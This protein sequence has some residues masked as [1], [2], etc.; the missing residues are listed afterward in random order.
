M[1]TLMNPK[2]T[3][4]LDKIYLINLPDRPD[5]LLR[6]STMLNFR[7][8]SFCVVSA[9]RKTDG[10]L[11]LLMT[12]Q[13]LWQKSVDEG[14]ERV[15]I[16]EDDINIVGDLA[17]MEKVMEQLPKDFDMLYLGC[18]LAQPPTV[19][20]ANILCVHRALATHAVVYSRKAMTR[21]LSLPMHLPVDVFLANTI[22]AAGNCYCTYPLLISQYPGYS[23]IEKR[24]T[25]WTHVLEARFV[26][27]TK[28]L[29]PPA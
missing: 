12:L 7:D 23:D 28:H 16:L 18:N 20:S 13:G 26:E 19:Y 22:Q 5:R 14:L 2:W 25:D 15:L 9:T 11:G 27:R 6:A 4:F 21:L 10:R 3:S 1:V 24:Q 29:K 8:L 17:V